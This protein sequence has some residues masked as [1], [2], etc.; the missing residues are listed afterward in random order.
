MN[1]RVQGRYISAG[2]VILFAGS[3]SLYV[4]GQTNSDPDLLEK[5]SKALVGEDAIDCGRVA[6]EG[7]PKIASDCALAAQAAGKPFR[8]RYEMRG[9]DSEVA[10]VLLRTPGGQ[11]LALSYDSDITGRGARGFEAVNVSEC[12]TPV[13]LWVNPKGRLN[14]FQPKLAPPA[15]VTA[16]NSEPY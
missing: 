14:C 11:V 3:F 1:R 16:P 5:R 4:Y 7:D 2:L 10:V 15:K 13:H 8:V 6:I 12:P 9:F